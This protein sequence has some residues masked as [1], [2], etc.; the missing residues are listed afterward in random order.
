M[1]AQASFTLDCF[2]KRLSVFLD[3]NV[4]VALCPVLVTAILIF[5]A[6]NA[7]RVAQTYSQGLTAICLAVVGLGRHCVTVGFVHHQ[8]IACVTLAL[9]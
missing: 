5:K 4:V 2:A 7:T 9:N 8:T 6:I 1:C 3:V